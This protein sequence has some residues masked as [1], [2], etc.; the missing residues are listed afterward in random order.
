MK[1]LHPSFFISSKKL[2]KIMENVFPESAI[3]KFIGDAG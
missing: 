3:A 2:L 1:I